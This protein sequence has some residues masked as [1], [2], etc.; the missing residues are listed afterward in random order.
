MARP[1]MRTATKFRFRS[2][3][4]IGLQVLIVSAAPPPGAALVSFPGGDYN[5]LVTESNRAEENVIGDLEV[6]ATGWRSSSGR[7]RSRRKRPECR[8]RKIQW[9]IEHAKRVPVWL[10]FLEQE[11]SRTNREASVSTRTSWPR[12]LDDS[13]HARMPTADQWVD[14]QSATGCITGAVIDC[15]KACSATPYRPCHILK[16]LADWNELLFH[17]RMQLREMP[18]SSG[19]LA[20]VN[21]DD[22]RL[23]MGEPHHFEVQKSASVM[24]HLLKHHRCVASLCIASFQ[25]QR[26]VQ[27][28][29]DALPYTGL[30]K[31]KMTCL[32]SLMSDGLWGAIS[33][34]TSLEELECSFFCCCSNYHSNELSS[35]LATLVQT[36]P[37]LVVLCL[38]GISLEEQATK[39]LLASLTE[40]GVLRELTFGTRVIPDTCRKELAR[41]LML[42]PSLMSFSYTGD[43]EK[44][45]IAVLEGVLHNR[46][47]SKVTISTFTGHAVSIMLAA[48]IL[49][50]SAPI[51]TFEIN[52]I[53]KDFQQHNILY[54]I[55]LEAPRK[56]DTLEELSFPCELWNQQQ[57]TNFKSILSSKPR[58]K[59][60]N[61]RSHIDSYE[62]LSDVC[63]ALEDSGVDHKMSC[64]DY[65]V[66]D[67]IDLLKCKMFS[68][69]TFVNECEDLEAT[70]LRQLLDSDHLTSLVLQIPKGNLALCSA[71][72][73]YLQSTSVLRKLQLRTGHSNGQGFTQEWWHIIVRSLS[74]NKSIK[75]LAFFAHNMSDSDVQA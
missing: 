33:S 2:G 56:N 69:L 45:E 6:T 58:L 21:I 66:E 16:Q 53:D 48:R 27:P 72:A 24:H 14:L 57:W 1:S 28:L 30:K 26:Y 9:M 54:D 38:T 12:N 39:N 23:Y 20:M 73:K 34:L 18:G 65:L 11:T 70:A 50:K 60:F 51:K 37:S 15:C 22:S 75:K 29:R 19:K 41:Y 44:T 64:G 68:G 17:A 3:V 36:S 13:N 31:L 8:R 59:R 62:Y 40:K 63:H 35:A 7:R 71:L 47:L 10:P 61:I 43:T 55:W 67:N 74:R 49:S 4:G 42:T 5:E 52:Y 46:T 25:F 32:A